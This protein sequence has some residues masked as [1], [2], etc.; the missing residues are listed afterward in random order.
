VWGSVL[1]LQVRL[2]EARATLFYV[3]NWNLISQADD[4]FAEGLKASPLRHMWSL[5]VEEQ[6]YILW[7]LVLAGVWALGVR[8]RKLFGFIA[9]LTVASA[10]AMWLMYDPQHVSRVYYGTDT[11]VFQPLIGAGLAVLLE[12]RQRATSEAPSKSPAPIVAAVALAVLLILAWRIPSGDTSY[13]HG[14]AIAIA[15]VAAVLIAALEHPG[16]VGKVLAWEPLVHLG[17]IS[18]GVY[19]WHF[20]ITL[21]VPPPD[22]ASWADRRVVNIIQFALT[23]ALAEGSYRLVELPLR[24]KARVSRPLVMSLAACSIVAL[25]VV[26]GV[27]LKPPADSLALSATKDRSYKACPQNPQPCVKVK[28]AT[29]AAKT[30]VL[31]GDSTA[32]AYN[33]ALMVLAKQYGFNYVQAAV[34]G[35]PI[36]HRLLATGVNGE[37]H[38][39]SNFMCFDEMPGIYQKVLDTWNPALV[40]A[41]S[42]NEPS[43]HMDGDT[44]VKTGT[45]THLTQTRA[46][47]DEAVSTLTSKGAKLVFIDILPGGPGVTCLQASAPNQGTCVRPVLPDSVEK[48]YNAMFAAIAEADP[49]VLGT[50]SFTDVVCP[51]DACQLLID[52]VVARY[53][54]GHY[55]GTFSK[56][57]APLLYDRLK[58]VGIDLATLAG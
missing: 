15:L 33:P 47:L 25:A 42:S 54:G 46:A 56:K 13:F 30:V 41:T 48:Q 12:R 6:F 1:E 31:V 32:Q 53:D 23:L 7:P 14:G 29:P 5:A 11:R 43:Q 26:A 58:A 49:A 19:L 35:C 45:P 52:G 57:I 36:G 3:A 55:T 16:L 50:V 4:Y 18:Y 37:L 17:V 10:V 28:G 8:G 21:W 27:L 24:R 39:S 38:K 9:V 20:P 40:I 34:G 44:V 2:R 22:G 51:D